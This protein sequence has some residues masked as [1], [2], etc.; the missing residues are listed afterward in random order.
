MIGPVLQMLAAISASPTLSE[1]GPAIFADMQSTAVLGGGN[2]AASWD[3]VL[4]EVSTAPPLLDIQGFT[5]DRRGRRAKCAFVVMRIAAIN[6]SREDQALTRK[7]S[8]HALFE[9][10]DNGD[11]KMAWHV[12]RHSPPHKWGPGFTTMA[13]SALS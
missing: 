2:A 1:V 6:A 3:W 9:A 5:C 11:G 8:C 12:K 4:G 13:C 10:F 7:L